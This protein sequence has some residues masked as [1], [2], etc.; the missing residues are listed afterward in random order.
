MVIKHEKQNKQTIKI[1]KTILI[2][3]MIGN[4]GAEKIA[5]ALMRNTTLN[6]LN[7][8]CHK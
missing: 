4:K 3:A 7:L 6:E 1:V 8:N 5:E 2:G